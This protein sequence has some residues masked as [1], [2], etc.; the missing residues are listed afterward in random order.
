M[1]SDPTGNQGWFAD[2]R[3]FSSDYLRNLGKGLFVACGAPEDEA[4]I[5]ADEL[6]EASLMGLDSH[7]VMRF[8]QYVDDAVGGRVRP[9]A[10]T[11]VIKETPTTA[12]VDCGFNF[13]PVTAT[14]MAEI[15]CA[16]AAAANVACVIS[17]NG[18]HVG[19]VGAYVQKIAARGMFGLAT[20]NSSK[21]G[22][23][24]AP[25]GGREGRLATNPVA[26]AAPTSSDPV[27]LD[28]STAAIAEG[29]IRVLMNEGKAV[30]A[31]SV[32][33]AHGD[34]VT[35]PRAFYGPP[36]GTILPF[37]GTQGYKGFG[38][39]LLTEIL[40]GI[41]A[42]MASSADHPYVN[43]LSLI[44]IDPEAF[45]GRARFI[46]LMDDLCTYQTSSLAAHGYSEV[47][48]P[49]AYDFRMRAKRIVE[50]IPVA[51][52]TWQQ[53]TDTARRLNVNV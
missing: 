28:M 14:R 19:R 49:G 35:D 13:G 24:V 38:L 16:K 7:G 8:A 6:V 12:L 47:V 9:G 11:R 43:G 18:H 25:W 10:P 23:W 41:M 30:P 48:M 45:C 44:A 34:F 51:P 31:E 46:E 26:Y 3:V 50:G 5:V 22:H 42:G 53:I 1:E 15:A 29:K 17:Q 2:M 21:H 33:D 52:Q 20:C 37:G 36:K 39:S 27:V 4:A 32:R 40:G